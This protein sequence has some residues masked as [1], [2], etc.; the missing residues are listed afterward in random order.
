MLTD[1]T[2]QENPFEA[3]PTLSE[4]RRH[5]KQIVNVSRVEIVNWATKYL[6]DLIK[7]S[8]QTLDG[9]ILT[10]LQITPANSFQS[11]AKFTK[12]SISDVSGVL[13]FLF[14]LM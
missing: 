4:T 10:V 14:Y 8:R 2:K 12:N 13:D 11:L 6:R 9:H 7:H 5:I 1:S 3:K